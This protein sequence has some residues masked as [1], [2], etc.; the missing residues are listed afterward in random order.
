MIIQRFNNLAFNFFSINIRYLVWPLFAFCMASCKKSY[1]PPE[2]NNPPSYIVIEGL[3]NSGG[4]STIIKITTT[5]NVSST[6][7]DSVTKALVSVEDDQNMSVALTEKNKGIYV[8]PALNIDKTR[9]YRLRVITTDKQVYL[10][11]FVPV[12]T[13]PAIDS[14]G[15]SIRND[16]LQVYVNT[17]DATNN[18]KYYRWDYTET[19]QF[20]S[21][22]YSIAM[23]QGG[24][25]LVPRTFS[26][27]IYTCYGNDASSDIPLAT[28]SNLSHGVLFQKPIALI[29]STSEKL[30]TRFSIKVNQYALTAGAYT[31][32]S[33][34]EQN[35]TQLGGIFSPM[36]SDI[37][38]NIHCIS[39]PSQPV[40][41]YISVN[42]VTSKRIFVSK[43]SLPLLW[44]PDYPASCMITPPSPNI[45]YI[46]IYTSE[47]PKTFEFIDLDQNH[48]T[49]ICVDCTIRGNRKP[50]AF[51]IY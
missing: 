21:Y 49:T 48:S 5:S 10:S 35:G 47:D 45:N 15:Y 20:H 18:V 38:G 13:T 19:W 30:E 36:P 2:L 25:Y 11:D 46:S 8:S 23:V 7:A 34:L 3:I 41:G 37:A 33:K 17:H 16:G 12:L 26:N 27:D 44:T 6:S 31:F 24:R 29:P 22:Y 50:P 32:Y 28:T 1:N 14:V 4:D 51:W 42:N 39:N 40:L 9:N 43:S